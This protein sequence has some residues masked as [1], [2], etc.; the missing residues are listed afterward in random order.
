MPPDMQAVCQN[1][2]DCK[3]ISAIDIGWGHI[4]APP[5]HC[6]FVDRMSAFEAS[7]KAEAKRSSALR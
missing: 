4:S 3:S 7:C 6:P 2:Y 1:T 5:T